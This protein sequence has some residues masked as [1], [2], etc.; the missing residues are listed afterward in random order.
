M[1]SSNLSLAVLA[2][3]LTFGAAAYAK[4]P[5]NGQ[6]GSTS[7]GPGGQNRTGNPGVGTATRTQI[8]D[9]T[10]LQAEAQIRARLH[11]M[12]TDS[13]YGTGYVGATGAGIPRGI[14]TPG[15]GLTTTVDSVVAE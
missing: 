10:Q 4:G 11:T 8:Q 6:A 1:K 13:T 3:M 9:G 15:T 12:N 5:M 7:A 2:L 14:H